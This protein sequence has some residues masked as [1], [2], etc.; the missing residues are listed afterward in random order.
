MKLS[1]GDFLFGFYSNI[2]T[3]RE[4]SVMLTPV[5][6]L[7]DDH[8]EEAS[9]T[10]PCVIYVPEFYVTVS[11]SL[12]SS[13]INCSS[14]YYISVRGILISVCVITYMETYVFGVGGN[15]DTTQVL[16]PMV[17]EWRQNSGRTTLLHV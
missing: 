3:P 5:T 13:N 7:R 17:Q 1:T 8:T 6:G 9:S 11:G 10:S 2:E 4:M 12:H 14:T 16:V 15:T